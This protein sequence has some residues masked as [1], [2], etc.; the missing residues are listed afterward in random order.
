VTEQPRYAG[1][2]GIALRRMAPEDIAAGMRLKSLAGWNQTEDD[3]RRFLGEPSSGEP[4]S[5][6]FAAVNE[7]R[8]V[9]TVAAIRYGEGDLGWIGMALVD[10]AFRRQGIG[11]LLLQHAVGRLAVCRAT[12]LDAT[13]AGEALYE[14]MGFIGESRL[15]RLTHPGLPAL[16]DPAEP[17][18][19]H[20]TFLRPP[21]EEAWPGILALDRSV[22]GAD[23]AWLLRALAA[24]DPPRAL[25]LV[26]AGRIEGFCLGR[27]GANYHQIGPLLAARAEDALVL[28][29]AAMRGLHGRPVALDVPDT[30]SEL[31]RWLSDRGFVPQRPFL[32][33]IRGQPP[34]PAE[35]DRLFA[36]CGPEFG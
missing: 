10:P 27:P 30:Q 6:C 7:G 35:S 25:C 29:R 4:A 19:S 5:E 33:M 20:R 28:A 14:T 17:D 9:G 11:R 34:A 13:P 1:P 36:I 24:G 16:P 23:R 22:F 8:V 32:R 21:T 18:L 26:R 31:L 3:W 2:G 12:R 15:H